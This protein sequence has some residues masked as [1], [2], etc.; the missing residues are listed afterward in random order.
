[1]ADVTVN[2]AGGSALLYTTAKHL[3]WDETAARWVTADELAPGDHLATTA[4]GVAIT[5]ARVYLFDSIQE[6][7]NL[8]VDVLHTYYVLAGT[9]PVLVHNCNTRLTQAQADT[10]RVGPHA[11][12]SVPATGPAV[13][14]EQSAAMQGLPCHTCGELNQN[15]TM[16]GD[17]QP[18][19]G[20]SP[21]GGEQNP[22]PQCPG[23][24]SAGQGTAVQRAQQILRNHGVYNPNAPGAY[25]RLLEL[26]PDHT[27]N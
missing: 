21:I 8:T 6:M 5:V 20:L 14:S 9:T 13:T 19:S 15:V 16:V 3:F 24:C 26:L 27:E 22:Y 23:T 17:H 12:E 1:M 10:L 7:D 4:G 25:E 11:N 18:P 2:V